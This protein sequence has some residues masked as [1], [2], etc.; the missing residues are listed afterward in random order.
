MG[1][2]GNSGNCGNSLIQVM[3]CVQLFSEEFAE[4]KRFYFY[5]MASLSTMQYISIDHTFKVAANVGYLRPDGRW[6]TE[7]DSLF[8]VLNNIG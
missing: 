7:Y 8:I 3:T 4:N 5:D 6:I 2:S 1:K